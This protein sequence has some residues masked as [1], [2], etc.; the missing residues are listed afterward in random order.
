MIAA[1]VLVALFALGAAAEPAIVSDERIDLVGLVERLSGDPAAAVNPESDAAAERFSRW[2]AHPAV[3]DLS[4]MRSGG[5]AGNVPAQYAVYL[6]TPPELRERYAPPNFFA[7]LA[8][9]AKPLAV[10]R[11]DLA[12]FVRVS[13]FEEWERERAPR[14]DAELAAVRAAAGGRELGGPLAKY[15][16]ARTWASWTVV[17]SPFFPHGGSASWV[18]EEKPGRPDIVVVYGPDR[19][20]GLFGV[21]RRS[22]LFRRRARLDPA[23]EFASAV[24][25]EAVFS[26]TYAIYEACRPVIKPA[27]GVCRGQTGL[28]DAEDCIQQS[29]VRGVVASLLESE[30]GSAEAKA[31][32]AFSPPTTYQ[33]R[34][35]AA[36]LAYEKD[37]AASPDLMAA[38]G[39]LLAPFQAD[40]LAPACRVEDHSRDAEEVYARRFK[41]YQEGRAAV[42]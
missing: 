5:F 17:V 11:E 40:G 24:W 4:R 15:L 35:D 31:Y 19:S 29:W 22:G 26:M 30:Y 23:A 16:G 33:D 1:P 2:K 41:Y 21:K 34:V 27:P 12:D 28:S 25:P 18:L 7:L 8:G 3:A 37:R 20:P 10:W 9:G 42:Q 6:S 39:S 32:R 38:S 13:G 36:L 14:R